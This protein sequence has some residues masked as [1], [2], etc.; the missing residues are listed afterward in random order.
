[1]EN[2]SSFPWFQLPASLPPRSQWLPGPPAGWF[3][4][5]TSYRSPKAGSQTPVQDLENDGSV[6]L[7]RFAPS[8][9]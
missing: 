6:G 5:P 4:S 7:Q 3:P 1:M 2:P 9:H 8:G